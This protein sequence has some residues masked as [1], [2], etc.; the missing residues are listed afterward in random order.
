[1]KIFS[2]TS[3][4]GLLTLCLILTGCSVVDKIREAFQY[5]SVY[6]R[7]IGLGRLAEEDA[8]RYSAVLLMNTCM[9]TSGNGE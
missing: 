8:G 7:C 5:D 9:F 3:I 2:M 6:M 1:M 4:R